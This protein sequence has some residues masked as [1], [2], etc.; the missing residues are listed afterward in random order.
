MV[1]P[2][3]ARRSRGIS[4]GVNLFPHRKVCDLDCVYCEV[5]NP[6]TSGVEPSIGQLREEL[7]EVFSAIREGR[8][9]AGERIN[10]IAFSGDGEPTISPLFGEAVDVAADVRERLG[11]KG[12]KLVLITDALT[13][14]R[15]ATR[16]A[17]ERLM[18]N[19]G[20][21]WAKLDAGTEEYFRLVGRGHVPLARQ[22]ENI[23][24]LA[25]RHPT[26]IQSMFLRVKGAP[27]PAEEIDAYVARLRELVAEGAR[28]MRI[29]VY[30]VA[31]PTTEPWATALPDGELDAIAAKVRGALGDG[32]PV[33]TYP[34]HG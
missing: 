4:I 33:E 26:V 2:V 34:S 9:F 3:R 15:P 13:L 5:D 11:P 14:Q 24:D 29:D 25:R 32:I 6:G 27:P 8:S 18:A 7:E 1:Y 21:V 23:A 31:R 28:L 20:E 19:G 16:E 22:I 30:T 10:D 12:L 17:I